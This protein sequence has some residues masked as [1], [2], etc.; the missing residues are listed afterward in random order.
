MQV[1]FPFSFVTPRVSRPADAPAARRRS[2]STV[3]PSTVVFGRPR[4]AAVSLVDLLVPVC[5]KADASG[6]PCR[7]RS[8]DRKPATASFAFA[9]PEA[10]WTGTKRAADGQLLLL[11]YARTVLC[12]AV[13]A[14]VFL[15]V[16]SLR[17]RLLVAVVQNVF[18]SRIRSKLPGSRAGGVNRRKPNRAARQKFGASRNL[19]SW[20][21]RQV[22]YPKPN[23]GVTVSVANYFHRCTREC[24]VW[25]RSWPVSRTDGKIRREQ[26]MNLGN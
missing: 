4:R 1:L 20:Y 10:V 18:S 5:V 23:T 3:F 17:V 2:W 13:T 24:C 16:L 26:S 15:L 12:G 6:A 21:Y 9:G 25:N 14:V 11:C 8:G 19:M 22:F 7:A